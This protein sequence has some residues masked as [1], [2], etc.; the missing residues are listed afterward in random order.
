MYRDRNTAEEFDGDFDQRHTLNVFVLQRLS[1]RLAVSG[2][3]RVGSNFPIVGYFSGTPEAM[4]LASERN[5][6][7]LPLY[8]RLDVRANR[9]F[10]FQ[11][12]R[13]TLF[14]EVMNL[15]GRENGGQSDGFIRLPSLEAVGYVQGLLPRIP[16]AGFLFEF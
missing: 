1:Y 5:Q 16:S 8:S 10:T 12:S 6:V 9:T 11:R 7:R 3:L 13:L 4:H 14:V 2:K 15:L